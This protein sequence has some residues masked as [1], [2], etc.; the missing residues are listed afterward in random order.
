M[1]TSPVRHTFLKF[2]APN[3]WRLWTYHAPADDL[4]SGRRR[5][6]TLGFP[7]TFPKN[8]I[9]DK[10]PGIL[11]GLDQSAFIVARRRPGLLVLNFGILQLRGVSGRLCSSLDRDARGDLFSLP[12]SSSRQTCSL[13]QS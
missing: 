4:G 13:S 6:N 2:A 11:H 8:L 10:T 3:S 12:V 7:Q 9:V 1:D 5:S